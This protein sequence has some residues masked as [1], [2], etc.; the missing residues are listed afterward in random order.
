VKIFHRIQ[1]YVL[2]L[3]KVPSRQNLATD[4]NST[5]FY[6]EGILLTGSSTSS[7]LLNTNLS[8]IQCIS[9]HKVSYTC[10]RGPLISIWNLE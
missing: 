5:N 8:F 9:L 2:T 4:A 1:L 3:Q 6:L 10:E 7:K